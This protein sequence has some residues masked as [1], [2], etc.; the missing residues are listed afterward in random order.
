MSDAALPAGTLPDVLH[1][2]RQAS[3]ADASA[4]GLQ[5]A[6]ITLTMVI[7]TLAALLFLISSRTMKRDIQV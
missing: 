1:L 2:C 4:T 3:C 5:Y 6:M 7:C